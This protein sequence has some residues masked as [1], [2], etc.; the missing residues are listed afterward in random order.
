MLP[1]EVFLSIYVGDAVTFVWAIPKEGDAQFAR[2]NIG[3]VRV[4]ELVNRVR[5]GLNLSSGSLLDVPDFDLDAASQIYEEILKP[6]EDTLNKGNKLLVAANSTLAGLPFGL[7]PRQASRLMP[8][9]NP[10]SWITA[11]YL[12]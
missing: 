1:G 8:R 12:G 7:L 2:V 5:G 4:G 6:L 9:P 10:C 11:R 3:R